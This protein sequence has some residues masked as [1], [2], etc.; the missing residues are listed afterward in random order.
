MAAALCGGL[1]CD[2][3]PADGSPHRGPSRVVVETIT[4]DPA[5]VPFLLTAVGTFESPQTT[6]IASEVSGLVTFL[7]IPEG[8]EVEEG[9]V[10]ARVDSRQ[11]E[12]HLTVAAARY[13]N[14]KDT[15]T[16]LKSLQRD[17]LISRQELDDASSKLEQAAGELEESRTG[18]NLTEIDAPF[19]GQLGL[20]QVSLGAFVDAGEAIVRLTQTNPLRLT[21]TVPERDASRLA[22]GQKIL[23]I[24]GDCT[25]RFET[26]VSIIDPT[27]EASTRAIRA[28]ATVVSSDRTLRP[29]MSARL[30]VEIGRRVAALTV[31]HQAVVRRGT[32]ELIY[33]V[34]PDGEIE[35]RSVDLGQHFSETVEVLSGINAGESIVVAGQQ[36]IRPGAVADPR[37]YAP[38]KNPKLAL[39]LPTTAGCD[40]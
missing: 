35:E 1:G 19:T 22:P 14:A 6:M 3:S 4:V 13:R 32:R 33:V 34:S 20:R 7:D 18:V 21:F 2:G 15:Y 27:V 38:V 37:P 12:A 39:G 11:A 36:K 26:E 29:G 30:S 23:G 17:G 40:L 28:Q 24:A 31:P 8:R 9:T 25:A 5:N 10:L 16:R